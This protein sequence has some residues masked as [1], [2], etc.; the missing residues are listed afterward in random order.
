MGLP[1]LSA[2]ATP[3]MSSSSVTATGVRETRTNWVAVGEVVKVGPGVVVLVGT[4]V[5]LGEGK[6]WV[7]GSFWAAVEVGEGGPTV[8]GN[9]GGGKGFSGV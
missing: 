5:S 1:S 3:D 9:V 4:G 8:G 2:K 6:V 7:G